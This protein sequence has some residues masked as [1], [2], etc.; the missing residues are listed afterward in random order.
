MP[1]IPKLRRQRQENFCEFGACF[2]YKV[3]S[4]TD[5]AITHR[6]PVSKNLKKKLIVNKSFR[7]L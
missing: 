3:S 1:L 7:K 5:R 6:N 2:I 4:T